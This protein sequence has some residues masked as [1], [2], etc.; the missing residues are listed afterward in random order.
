MQ[1]AETT[2]ATT[3]VPAEHGKA[4]FPP[5]DQTTFASQIFWLTITFGF[6][7]VVLWRVAGPRI[8]G[9]IA[10]RR[11]AIN[12]DLDEAARQRDE[13]EAAG[14]AYQAALT[15]ARNSARA[16][17]EENRKRIVGEIE[18]AKAK[19]DAD[20]QAAM[21]A[22]EQ[23][24]AAKRAEAKAHVTKAA[25]EAAVAIVARL[26]GETVSAVEAEAAL[27]ATSKG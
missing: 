20:A 19:A 14:A 10:L 5:F 25:S 13:A 3:E 18:A 17:A 24:I 15:S 26:T 16:L 9:A 23:R 21:A 4:N 27:P 7:F 11:N 2:H 6:L 8:Q 12:K 1:D 22:A